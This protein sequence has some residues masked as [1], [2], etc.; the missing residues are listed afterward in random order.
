MTLHGLNI[1]LNLTEILK[2]IMVMKVSK[3]IF[4]KVMFNTQKLYIT[5][6]KLTQI[7]KLSQI[8]IKPVCLG[9]SILKLS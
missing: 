5:S 2:T 8:W 1:Y 9:L 3:D 7:I 6:I 4:L